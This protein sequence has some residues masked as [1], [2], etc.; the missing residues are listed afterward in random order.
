[1][2]KLTL[3]AYDFF[4]RDK[5]ARKEIDETLKSGCTQGE[6]HLVIEK[7]MKS[8]NDF[9]AMAVFHRTHVPVVEAIDYQEIAYMLVMDRD[10]IHME[11]VSIPEWD[12]DFDTNIQ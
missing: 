10:N 2:N 6:L 12:E 7:H 4:T 1:M 9:E 5:D 3:T 11:N 8:M